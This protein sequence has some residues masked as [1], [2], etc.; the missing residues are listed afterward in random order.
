MSLSE[1]PAQ[2]VIP[3]GARN[4]ALSVSNAVRD[5]SS[6][7]TPRNDTQTEIITQT[8]HEPGPWH[9]GRVAAAR[10]PAPDTWLSTLDPLTR[11]L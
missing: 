7:V 9:R 5:S 4:L 2:V 8:P 3:S 1:N 11:C 6:P 10:E